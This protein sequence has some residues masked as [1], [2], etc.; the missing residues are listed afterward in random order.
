MVGHRQAPP[1]EPPATSMLDHLLVYSLAVFF[2]FYLTN[3]SKLPFVIVARESLGQL[4]W[5]PWMLYAVQC[6]FCTAFWQT[7]VV[8][9]FGGV[10]WL[11]V[12]AAPSLVLFQNLCYQRLCPILATS[13]TS[14]TL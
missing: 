4:Y 13:T 14:T 10:P 7:L 11:F 3:H 8:A 6:A 5:P 12:L 1:L 2:G 9:I